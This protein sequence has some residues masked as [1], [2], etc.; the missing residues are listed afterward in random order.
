[1]LV[2]RCDILY[3]MNTREVI[4]KLTRQADCRKVGEEDCDAIESLCLQSWDEFMRQPRPKFHQQ[5]L[6]PRYKGNVLQRYA[7]AMRQLVQSIRIEQKDNPRFQE[8]S[9]IVENLYKNLCNDEQTWNYIR[10]LLPSLKIEMKRDDIK[11]AYAKSILRL[12][13]RRM[14]R[15]EINGQIFF[16]NLR[17]R[18][19]DN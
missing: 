15:D 13:N 2:I 14:K 3:N 17:D 5:W 19:I 6:L 4:E 7:F 11:S 18:A 12:G 8:Y 9:Q 16:Q 10:E 1:M